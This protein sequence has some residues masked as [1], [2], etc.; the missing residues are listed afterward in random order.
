VNSV[1]AKYHVWQC[2]AD[3][4]FAEAVLLICLPLTNHNILLNLVSMVC[5]TKYVSRK[6]QQLFGHCWL[7]FK[8]ESF[9]TQLFSL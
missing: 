2:L 4:L 5:N 7:S 9:L 3:K 6:D 1:I 8:V